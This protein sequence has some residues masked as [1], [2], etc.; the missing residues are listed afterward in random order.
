MDTGYDTGR[1]EQDNRQ[2][3][4]QDNMGQSNNRKPLSEWYGV[5]M[6]IVVVG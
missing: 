3:N 6:V 1:Y 4:R 5:V 2:D